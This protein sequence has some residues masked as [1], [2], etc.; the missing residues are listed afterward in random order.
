M[1]LRGAYFDVFITQAGLNADELEQAAQTKGGVPVG[2][3]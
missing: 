1:A 2:A 3:Q